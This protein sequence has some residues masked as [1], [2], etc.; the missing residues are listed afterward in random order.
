MGLFGVASAA[1]AIG[2]VGVASAGH[3]GGNPYQ[4]PRLGSPDYPDPVGRVYLGDTGIPD[5][6]GGVQPP[7]FHPLVCRQPAVTGSCDPTDFADLAN[8]YI[9]L[10]ALAVAN[11]TA[12]SLLDSCPIADAPFP[13]QSIEQLIG[14]S[15]NRSVGNSCVCP[16][17]AGPVRYRHRVVMLVDR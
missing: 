1:L 6:V 2:L 17:V 14:N 7:F 4:R 9:C 16:P 5:Y 11:L 12:Q 13:Y 15:C 3:A 10:Q 8:G